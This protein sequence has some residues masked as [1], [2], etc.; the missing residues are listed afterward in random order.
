[1]S[2]FASLVGII[3]ALAATGAWSESTHAADADAK[4]LKGKFLGFVEGDSRWAVF[5]VQGDSLFTAGV[6]DPYAGLFVAAL[7]GAL[8][9]IEVQVVDTYEE[10]G[11]QQPIYGLVGASLNGY[12]AK[13][14]GSDTQLALGHE[15]ANRLFEALADSMVSENEP[16]RCRGARE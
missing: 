3:I 15:R 13:Q 10:D 14:W 12:S 2:R 8:L 4:R 9:D 11:A 6:S 7:A 16:L 1:M 5:C